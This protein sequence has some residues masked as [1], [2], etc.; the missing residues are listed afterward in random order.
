MWAIVSIVVWGVMNFLMTGEVAGK[1]WWASLLATL[2]G[3]WLGDLLLGHWL[4]VFAGY[5]IIAGAIGAIVFNWL[6]S[7]VRR[8]M[9]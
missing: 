5:N 3:G 8:N 7:L 9:Y 2:I 6:W 4:W 1:D